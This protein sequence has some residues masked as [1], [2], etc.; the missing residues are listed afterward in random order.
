MDDALG[1]R[2]FESLGDLKREPERLAHGRPMRSVE[3]VGQRGT[4]DQF[5]DEKPRSFR[6]FE[7]VDACNVGMVE[8]REKSRLAIEARQAIGIPR[9]LVG[10]R[11]DRHLPSELRVACAKHLAHAAPAERRH[12]LVVRE[13]PPNHAGASQSNTAYLFPEVCERALSTSKK[14]WTNPIRDRAVAFACAPRPACAAIG[15]TMTN[16][17]PAGPRRSKFR[18]SNAA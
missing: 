14:L 17:S 12:D 6:F 3:P 4:L 8:R 11:L 1:V 7:T 15:T 5:E 18:S 2:G 9:V 10:K 16:S 13:R